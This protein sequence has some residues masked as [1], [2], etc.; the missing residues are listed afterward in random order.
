MTKRILQ[1]GMTSNIGGIETYLFR[2]FKY[3][4]KNRLIFDFIQTYGEGEYPFTK[5][6][7]AMGG[8]VYRS[9]TRHAT[10]LRYYL[11]WIKFWLARHRE[12]HGVVVNTGGLYGSLFPLVLAYLCNIRKRVVFSHNAM[13]SIKPGM[14]NIILRRMNKFVLDHFAN[15]YFACG[16]AAGKILFGAK[17]YTVINVC[18]EADHFKFDENKRRKIRCQLNLGSKLVIGHVGRFNKQKNQTFLVEVMNE[19]KNKGVDAIL[20]LIG[21]H[22]LPE[23]MDFYTRVESMIQSLRLQST[24]K[25]LGKRDDVAELMMAMDVF[26]LPSLYEGFPGVGVEA[27]ATGLPCYFADTITDEIAI[28]P[29]AHFLPIDNPG[30]WADALSIVSINKQRDMQQMIQ[31][32]GYDIETAI[33]YIEDCYLS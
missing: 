26:V 14:F 23:D 16:K 20:L 12:Y 1:I 27:Q 33:S 8:R 10:P 29:L 30:K 5:E 4:D 13:D 19:L 28:T 17:T 22:D 3:L 6:V 2:Q 18:V 31:E 25:I 32:S 9:P 15:T 24:V 21:G 11:F 7:Q